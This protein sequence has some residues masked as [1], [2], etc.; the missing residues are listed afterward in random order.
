MTFRP[1]V[2]AVAPGRE[3]R[4]LGHLGMPGLFDGE[5]VFAIEP[6]RPGRVRFVHRE[7]FT[8]LLVPVV[9]RWLEAGTRRGFAAMNEALRARAERGG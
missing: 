2:L 1:R 9:A 5:H 7:V 4:W 6:G 8:G 3:L